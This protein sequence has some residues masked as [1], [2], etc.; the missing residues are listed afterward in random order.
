MEI[1]HELSYGVVFNTDAFMCGYHIGFS[2][3]VP[4]PTPSS[5]YATRVYDIVNNFYSLK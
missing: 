3:Y 2:L 4:H 5:F 1:R